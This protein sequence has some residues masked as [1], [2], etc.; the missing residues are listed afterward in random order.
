MLK[1]EASANRWFDLVS[2]DCKS[3][4][5]LFCRVLL[6]FSSGVELFVY[7]GQKLVAKREHDGHLFVGLLYFYI[8][9]F[10]NEKNKVHWGPIK[11]G[12]RVLFTCL[13]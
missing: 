13:G 11:R 6:P 9:F 3:V 8:F 4:V 2:I 1:S 12:E 5:V 7:Y 10:K